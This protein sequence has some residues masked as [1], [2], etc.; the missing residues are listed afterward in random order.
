[1]MHEVIILPDDN[2]EIKTP[3]ENWGKNTATKTRLLVNCLIH[4]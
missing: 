2:A 4:I 1:M 3:D